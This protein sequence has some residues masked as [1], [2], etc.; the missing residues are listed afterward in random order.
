VAADF[1]PSGHLGAKVLLLGGIHGDE[2]SSVTIVFKWMAAMEAAPP[3]TLRWRMLPLLNP[4]G[5]LRE[6]S[7]RM[8]HNGVDLN[9]NFP[10]PDWQRETADYWV[11]RTGRN[12]RRYPG[13]SPLSE[14]ESRFLH[15]EIERF[16]PDI[17][18]AVHAPL[19]VVDFDGP[20]VPPDKLGS[21]FLQRMGTYPGSLG[22]YGGEQI[23]VPVITIELPSA[24]I[25]PPAD[26]QG[27]IWSDLHDYIERTL[28]QGEAETPT[29]AE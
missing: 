10:T 8:N 6:K 24:T 17:I 20:R 23:G 12:P 7:Q 16:Q 2:Y 22:R 4:D 21:L 1:A 18:V 15:H 9:R 29:T 26:E 14:P 3:S 5:L 27:R 13:P 25:M 11:R 19:E 28:C